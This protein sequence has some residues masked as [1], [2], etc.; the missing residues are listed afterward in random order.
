MFYV[1]LLYFSLDNIV[2]SEANQSV[3]SF[4]LLDLE[5]ATASFLRLVSSFLAASVGRV[6]V[7]RTA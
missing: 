5:I 4:L 3:A 7:A 2:H 6:A 1:L